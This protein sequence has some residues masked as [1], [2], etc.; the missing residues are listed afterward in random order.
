[1]WQFHKHKKIDWRLA[2]R[3]LLVTIIG[4]ILGSFAAIYFLSEDVAQKAIGALA[5][6][7]GTLLL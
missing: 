7:A 3:L 2:L 1:M 6:V 5:L 4:A